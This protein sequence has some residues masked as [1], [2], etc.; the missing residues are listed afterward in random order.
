[1]DKPIGKVVA[2]ALRRPL[3]PLPAR[4]DE[5]H[6]VAGL[7]LRDDIH[8]DAASPRQVLLAGAA[9]YDALKLAPHA[10]RE[11][12]LLD[13]DTAALGSGMLLR[14]GSRATFRLTFQCE[15]CG[16]L[17]AHAPGALRAIGARRGMLARVVGGG[18]VR[19]GD[20]VTLLE[21]RM[22]A[23]P[24]DWRERVA[25]VLAAVPEGMVVGYADLARMA[26]IQSSYCRTFPRMLA[27]LRADHAAKAA[28]AR[29]ATGLPR[30]DGAGL[31]E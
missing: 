1:M 17:E 18:S 10:L 22:P 15:A 7:G 30:W 25:L 29:A 12:L 5:A 2:L 23:L 13:L 26:G 11:N 4:V 21:R 8:A 20:T 14:I 9:V 24:E 27:R 31:F 16:R 6:A 19:E 3:A 28:P